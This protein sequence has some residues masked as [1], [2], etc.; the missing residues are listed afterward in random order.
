MENSG[1]LLPVTFLFGSISWRFIIGTI[2]L[3][4]F[5][6]W[7]TQQL[8]KPLVSIHLF[9]YVSLSLLIPGLTTA[10]EILP[11]SHIMRLAIWDICCAIFAMLVLTSLYRSWKISRI[12]VVLFSIVGLGHLLTATIFDIPLF[13]GKIEQIDAR[14]FGV[15]TTFIPLV[16]VSHIF[17]LKILWTKW[18][19][20][21]NP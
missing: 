12:L 2:F 21:K 4:Q 20:L 18:A 6:A 14:L 16:F 8:L 10:K 1:W 11:A 15:L 19:D 9:R 17:I 7:S 3:P 5:K 13:V